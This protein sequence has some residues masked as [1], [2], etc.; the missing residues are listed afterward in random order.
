MD[1]LS[2]KHWLL[3]RYMMG[4]HTQQWKWLT[5]FT[6][7]SPL[8]ALE[9]LGKKQMKR[10]RLHLPHVVKILATMVVLMCLAD[11][12]FFPPCLETDLADRVV[13]AVNDNFKQVSMLLFP[14][15]RQ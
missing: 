9:A 1:F 12:F 10:Y 13:T 7:Q 5:F 15:V 6:I 4:T 8:L 14:Q 3:L 2:V 11:R